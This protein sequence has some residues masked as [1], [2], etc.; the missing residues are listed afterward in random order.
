MR[1]KII[2]MV[3]SCLI[4]AALV[5][6][7]CAPKT[8]D[9]E[10]VGGEEAVSVTVEDEKEG[11]PEEEVALELE[12]VVSAKETPQYGGTLTWRFNHW[13]DPDTWDA[14][15]SYSIGMVFCDPFLEKPIRGDVE[16][17][18]PRG[19][20]EYD[21]ME[22][23]YAGPEKYCVGD[24]LESWESTTDPLSLIWH[25]RPG[26]YWTGET[27]NP[28][29][30]ERREFVAD[31][32]VYGIECFMDE[33]ISPG[34]TT[35]A[36][37]IKDVTALDKYTVQINL[38]FWESCWI[39]RIAYGWGWAYYPRESREAPGGVEDWKNL[40]GT[41]PFILEDYVEGSS[42][43]YV[44]NPDYWRT[45]TI[46]GIEYEIPFIDRLVCPIMTDESTILAATRTGKLDVSYAVSPRYRETL[47]KT[48]P[49]M[50][51]STW[52]QTVCRYLSFKHIGNVPVEPFTDFRVRQAMSMALDRES[53]VKNL[54]VEGSTFSWPLF[55]SEAGYY[56]PIE[57]MPADIQESYEY[58]PDKARQLLADAGYPDGFR[59]SML[60]Y[61][62]PYWQDLWSSVASYWGDIGIEVEIDTQEG[63][64]VTRAQ[65]TRDYDQIIIGSCACSNPAENMYCQYFPDEPFNAADWNDPWLIELIDK[66]RQSFDENEA[67]A[68]WKEAAQYILR[69]LPAIG[70]PTSASDLYWWPWV[71]NYYGEFETGQYCQYP[72]S[73]TIWIDQDLKKEMGY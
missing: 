61:S 70:L 13:D 17:Y 26:I 6:A 21:F 9:K 30:M 54:Y 50:N 22:L 19:T 62:S 40:C 35:R 59:T 16:K 73:S 25:V 72:L 3:L 15:R 66:A 47:A 32:I 57:E 23:E 49:E 53:M 42:V 12:E 43:T 24:L 44:R 2:W 58:N 63:N 68:M 38:N 27:I 37:F 4:V 60:V 48:S 64:V 8:A 31:D 33:E 69:Y 11:T 67:N 52:L 14:N 46:D 45:T 39:Y 5:L 20:N 55:P 56:T 41:G 7:S 71:K 28:G 29:V 1:R 10:E 65:Y 34:R 36:A 51:R 18:G